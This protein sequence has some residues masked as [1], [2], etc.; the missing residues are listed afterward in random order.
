MSITLLVADRHVAAVAGVKYFLADTEIDVV[1]EAGDGNGAV[2]LAL[3]VGPDCVLMAVRLPQEDGLSA[4]ARIKQARPALPVLMTACDYHPGELAQAHTLGAS[5]LLLKGFSRQRLVEAIDRAAAGGQIWSREEVRRV[6]GVLTSERLAVAA[7]VPLTRRER[8][9]LQ[10]VTR[11]Q[12]NRQIAEEL[13]IGC[14]TVKEHVQHIIRKI[15][16]K[17]R[18]Q[19]AVWAVRSRLV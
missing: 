18:T 7:G 19:A 2:E 10:C 13:G 8:D 3:S 5:G 17:D 15:G 11:G 1:A 16:V 12:T 4:L 9:V 6:T 14:E